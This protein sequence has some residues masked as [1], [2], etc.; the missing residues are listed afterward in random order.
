M[1]LAGKNILITGGANG[2]GRSLVKRLSNEGANVAVFDIDQEALNGLKSEYP[3]IY[4]AI[5]DVSN[6]EQVKSA[7]N[8]YSESHNVI[9]VLVNN[10][11]FIFSSPLLGFGKGGLVKHDIEMWEKVIRTDLSSVFYMT[12][13]VVEKMMAKRT[14]GVV[15]NISS[16]AASGNAGQSAYSAAK[17][18]VNALTVVW[19][20]E[21]S[22]MK[23]RFVGIAPGFTSTEMTMRS[24]DKVGL[25]GLVKQTPLRRLGAPDDITDAIVFAIRNDFVNGKVIEID[26]GLRL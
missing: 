10:A 14:K 17:A 25:E 11:G 22:P 16:I 5:C 26:G 2:I 20:K 3:G 6:C 13:H 9:D 23:I 4:C 7:I 12:V 19:A 15:I 1:D 24:V 21:L 8:E 18:G